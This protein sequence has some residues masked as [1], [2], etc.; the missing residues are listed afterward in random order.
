MHFDPNAVSCKC[1]QVTPLKRG[2]MTETPTR[3]R[4]KTYHCGWCDATKSHEEM[5]G[6][7]VVGGAVPST[8]ADCRN[9]NPGLRWCNYHKTPH[10]FDTF[11]IDSQGKPQGKYCKEARTLLYGE[12]LPVRTCINCG[13]TQSPIHFAGTARKS[14]VCKS[15]DANNPGL[16]WCIDHGAYLPVDKFEGQV[17]KPR[18]RVCR[19]CRFA[20]KHGVNI[21]E[22]T[23][24]LGLD[25]PQ[26]M[27]CFTTDDLVIDHDHACCP[28]THGCSKCVRGFLCRYCNMAEGLLR[29]P[30]IADQLAAYMRATSFR[31]DASSH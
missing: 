3:L 27:A 6:G 7:E 20:R 10:T 16:H 28:G 31:G 14:P 8:C 25:R 5:R 13:E 18:Y 1:N 12:K 15:C 17:G 19:T 29:T 21:F 26:C 4:N 11:V 24:R 30:E 2:S 23:A 9:T 22:M